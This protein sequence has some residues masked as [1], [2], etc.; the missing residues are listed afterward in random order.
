MS[1][2]FFCKLT[3]RTGIPRYSTEI[4]HDFFIFLVANFRSKIFCSELMYYFMHVFKCS[5]FYKYVSVHK[6]HTTQLISAKNTIICAIILQYYRLYR[7]VENYCFGS[8]G[9]SSVWC[10]QI[11]ISSINCRSV[12]FH[13]RN[14]F[15]LNSVSAKY[16]VQ[17]KTILN[18]NLC[19]E[20][21]FTSI[22]ILKNRHRTIL[23]QYTA[24][25]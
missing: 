12:E 21:I 6:Q 17:Q 23:R 19:I 5:Y 1:D 9:I 25:I 7:I 16:D 18:Q 22:E 13:R 11:N 24:R 20:I 3:Q 14:S 2:V 15:Q 10:K 4:S 8:D